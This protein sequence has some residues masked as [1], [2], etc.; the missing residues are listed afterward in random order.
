MK[1]LHAA[2]LPTGEAFP[3]NSVASLPSLPASFPL[4]TH[5]M[6]P[7]P[8]EKQQSRSREMC[9]EVALRPGCPGLP[10]YSPL[11]CPTQGESLHCARTAR[12]F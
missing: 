11:L 4:P 5:Y 1:L 10:G 8:Q 3:D 2:Q 9:T 7:P 12:Y 6:P